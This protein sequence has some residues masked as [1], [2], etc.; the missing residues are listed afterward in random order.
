MTTASATDECGSV[1]SGTCT[2]INSEFLEARVD[3]MFVLGSIGWIID[4]RKSYQV[5]GE[6]RIVHEIYD[7]FVMHKKPAVVRIYIKWNLP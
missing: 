4:G 6:Y 5:S 3:P 1:F 2:Q 7:I